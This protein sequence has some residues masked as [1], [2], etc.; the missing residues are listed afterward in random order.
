MAPT[1]TSTV[2]PMETARLGYAGLSGTY[3]DV[4]YAAQDTYGESP[5]RKN[6]GQRPMQHHVH[7]MHR[8]RRQ[9]SPAGS[10]AAQQVS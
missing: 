1:T 2:V 6:M 10:S 4:L 9:W 5:S 7:P 8:G 3:N